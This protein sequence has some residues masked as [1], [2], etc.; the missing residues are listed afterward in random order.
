MAKPKPGA[1]SCGGSGVGVVLRHLGQCRFAHQRRGDT[2]RDVPGEDQRHHCE[3]E[4]RNLFS[5]GAVNVTANGD[6]TAGT[7]SS[8]AEVNNLNLGLL[9]V[10]A[11]GASTIKS[12]CTSDDNAPV[13]TTTVTGLNLTGAAGA[14]VP[15]NPTPNTVVNVAGL[16]TLTFNEQTTGTSG[17]QKTLAVNALHVRLTGG[18]VATSSSATASAA[19]CPRRPRRLRPSPRWSRPAD[20]WSAA[21]P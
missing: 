6:T 7:S 8:S 18:T 15:T 1:S 3:R 12:T 19:V 10:Q 14:S 17:T 21:T 2:D 4:R 11:V 16:G 13:G 5:T 20:R 9:G